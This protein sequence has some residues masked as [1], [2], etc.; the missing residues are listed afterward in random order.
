MTN[1]PVANALELHEVTKIYG[2][3]DNAITALASATLSIAGNE[4]VALVGPSG[5]GKTTLL[6]IAGGLLSATSGQVIVGGKDISKAS[7]NEL[8]EVRRSSVGFVFQ[9]VNLV[10]F[11]TARENLMLVDELRGS[12]GKQSKARADRL[13]DELTAFTGPGVEQ[14]DDITLVVGKFSPSRPSQAGH[15]DQ[16]T[17]EPNAAG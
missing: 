16:R 10:P 11:L 4:I 9:S 2:E 14:E 15:R 12:R 1:T 5:S 13:L 3:G 8:T 7:A 6:S 17:T